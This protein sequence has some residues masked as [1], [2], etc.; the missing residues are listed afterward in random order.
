MDTRAA[1]PLGR[2]DHQPLS[3]GTGPLLSY[4]KVKIKSLA[5]EAA[6]IRMEERRTKRARAFASIRQAEAERVENLTTEL[7]GLHR[8]RVFDVRREQ[9]AALL[10]YACLRQRPYAL[11]EG[12]RTS[13]PPTP[14]VC[15]LVARFGHVGAAA[16]ERT[17]K[18]WLDAPP[19]QG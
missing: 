15:Q 4:L 7:A 5:A 18:A 8:H 2:N 19:R 16:A 3:K 10:A 13:A 6:I 1:R 14:S 12:S 11:V 17:V 9:R